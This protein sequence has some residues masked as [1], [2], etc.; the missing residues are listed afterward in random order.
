MLVLLTKRKLRP[1]GCQTVK[2][3]GI[4]AMPNIFSLPFFFQKLLRQIQDFFRVPRILSCS[5]KN[6]PN[7]L[8]FILKILFPSV[9]LFHWWFHLTLS[10]H[11][12]TW[13]SHWS[14]TLLTLTHVVCR[15]CSLRSL[16]GWRWRL[17]LNTA[18]SITSVAT[19]PA[20]MGQGAPIA[21]SIQ[22]GESARRATGASPHLLGCYYYCVANKWRATLK[23][24][25]F[26]M[27]S[28][29]IPYWSGHQIWTDAA[30]R[31]MTVWPG[32]DMTIDWGYN[33]THTV[34]SLLRVS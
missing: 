28:H 22:Q 2:P 1:D 21:S 16:W 29:L 26:W 24:R 5:Q 32:T 23:S 4:L 25:A 30:I 7:P 19:S 8:K 13:V 6:I 12:T 31:G 10:F 20:R 18:C 11:G 14:S 17:P 15:P 34:H 3:P 9:L 33:S 27:H